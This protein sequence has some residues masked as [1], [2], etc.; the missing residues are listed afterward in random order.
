M[1]IKNNFIRIMDTQED[2]V[3]ATNVNNC[4]NVIIV[5]FYFESNTNILFFATL[6]DNDKIK[7]FEEN[8]NIAFI[9]IPRNG[10]E[11][12]KARGTIKES[13]QT[14]FDLADRFINKIQDYKDNIEQFGQDLILFEIK[15]DTAIVT[16]DFEN[17]DTILLT[18]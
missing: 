17:I 1:I 8:P 18:K 11:H 12:V 9:T 4:T 16:L 6:R 2:I 7:E 3:L 10:T 15:F 14:I 5:N 13:N